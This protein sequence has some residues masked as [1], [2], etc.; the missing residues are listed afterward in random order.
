VFLDNLPGFPDNLN[1]G[2]NDTLW[3]A[4]G[5]PRVALLDNLAPYPFLRKILARLPGMSGYGRQAIALQFD[6]DGK[7]IRNLQDPDPNYP[8]LTSVFERDGTL[9]MGNLFAPGIYRMPLP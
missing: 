6:S 3:V 2:S 1:T 7:V 5:I 8:L 9:Y 4:L